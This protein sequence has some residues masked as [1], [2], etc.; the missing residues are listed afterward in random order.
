MNIINLL[1]KVVLVLISCSLLNSAYAR[2]PNVSDIEV[3][4]GSKILIVY[5]TRTKNTKAIAEIIHSKVGGKLVSVKLKTPYPENY[6]AIV[7][8][9]D[10]ENESGFLP[11]LETKIDDIEKY[12]IVF[13][14]FPTWDMQLPPPMKSFLSQHD[15]SGKKVIP[16]N[17]N[18]G[19]GVGSSFNDVRQLCTGC[20]VMEGFSMK[21]GLERDGVYLAIQGEK[22]DNA[23]EKVHQWLLELS[24]L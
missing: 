16:F 5:L 7:E 12:D 18:G 2:E 22:R 17:T 14:G 10:N 13:I 9:V 21:G 3:S 19:Y 20:N 4:E 23:R 8:Q 11:P 1:S 24:P 15:L 6:E